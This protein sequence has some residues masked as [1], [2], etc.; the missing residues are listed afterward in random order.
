[1]VGFGRLHGCASAGLTLAALE[2]LLVTHAGQEVGGLLLYDV[3]M[4]VIRV[5]MMFR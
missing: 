5:Q 1:M 4:T 2:P 3:R